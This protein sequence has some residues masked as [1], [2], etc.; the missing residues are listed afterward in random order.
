[1]GSFAKRAATWLAMAMK[2]ACRAAPSAE[3]PKKVSKAA[4]TWPSVAR[5][6]PAGA[7]P[8]IVGGGWMAQRGAPSPPIILE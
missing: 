3:V 6:T 5:V 2:A 4:M 8:I 1:M 7:G